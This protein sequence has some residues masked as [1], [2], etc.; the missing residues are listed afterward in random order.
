MSVNAG[1]FKLYPRATPTLRPGRYGVSADQVVAQKPGV[2]PTDNERLTAKTE[3]WDLQV[4]APRLTLGP[5]EILGSFPA[6]GTQEGNVQQLPHVTIRTR[7]MPWARGLSGLGP[8]TPWMALLLFRK[9]EATLVT[10]KTLGD[11]VKRLNKSGPDA[12]FPG[13]SQE[14]KN[15]VAAEPMAWVEAPQSV[16]RAILPKRDTELKLLAHV[17]EVNLSDSEAKG[18]DDGFVATV[19]CNRLP[20]LPNEEW[21][22]CLVNLE[23]FPAEHPMWP[24]P[25]SVAV[26]PG[27]TAT[28]TTPMVRADAVLPMLAAA[29]DTDAAKAIEFAGALDIPAEL[30]R[31][32]PTV[33]RGG[34]LVRNP[35]ATAATTGILRRVGSAELLPADVLIDL[36]RLRPIFDPRY[37]LPVLHQ[38]TFKT[39]EGVTDFESLIQAIGARKAS[40]KT[41]V[42]VGM[43]GEDVKDLPGAQLAV[44]HRTRGGVDGR[45][46]YRG[47]LVPFAM[48]VAK[49]GHTAPPGFPCDPAVLI[50]A[51]QLV[52][53][54]AGGTGIAP[55]DVPENV[56]LAVAYETGRLIALSRKDVLQ[57]LVDWQRLARQ[58]RMTNSL[59]KHFGR[60]DLYDSR[61]LLQAL[62]GFTRVRDQVVNP[63]LDRLR[64]DPTGLRALVDIANNP[65]PAGMPTDVWIFES[66]LATA[67]ITSRTALRAGGAVMAGITRGDIG[68]GPGVGLPGVAV[69]VTPIDRGAVLELPADLQAFDQRFPE[70]MAVLRADITNRGGR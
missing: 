33:G 8:D 3:R 4:V 43:L 39:A 66:G 25:F 46:Y 48:A 51:E 30:V 35:A 24:R 18:D 29:G 64:I 59:R 12:V 54:M 55:G 67:Q 31:S 15:N 63:S 22:A 26:V 28:I 47:P 58:V 38:W 5:E 44:S 56:S 10:T 13:I 50:A 61:G 70:L 19:L 68:Q 65:R 16:L 53:V 36:Q 2:A 40:A 60:F 21:L 9:S 11:Y 34:P 69:G 6:P 32:N 45:S 23:P 14:I 62:K 17:R 1:K 27:T 52:T 20:N 41:R 49:D 37:A 42:G 57:V 7:V